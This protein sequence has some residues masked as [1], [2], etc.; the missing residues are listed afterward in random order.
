[1]RHILRIWRYSSVKPDGCQIKIFGL[2]LDHAD[3]I[4]SQHISE[5]IQLPHAG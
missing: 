3:V 5:A 2:M 1:M 4:Q